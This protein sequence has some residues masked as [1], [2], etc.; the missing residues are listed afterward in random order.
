MSAPKRKKRKISVRSKSSSPKARSIPIKERTTCVSPHPQSSEPAYPLHQPD[1]DSASPPPPRPPWDEI[2]ALS[3][4]SQIPAPPPNCPPTRVS[5]ESPEQPGPLESL[6]PVARAYEP[7]S[8][9]LWRP[10]SLHPVLGCSWNGTGWLSRQPAEQAEEAHRPLRPMVAE[11]DGA[12]A[13]T[14]QD[15]GQESRALMRRKPW[16]PVVATAE[17]LCCRTGHADWFLYPS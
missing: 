14:G 13:E 11:C 9:P 6:P 1:P 15:Q 3:P 17:L 10:K 12:E 4:A 7:P 5:T 16:C 2:E 8:P